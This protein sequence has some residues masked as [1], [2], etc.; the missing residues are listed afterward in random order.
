MNPKK[1]EK[2]VEDTFTHD[3]VENEWGEVLRKLAKK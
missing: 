3:F 1:D 2:K